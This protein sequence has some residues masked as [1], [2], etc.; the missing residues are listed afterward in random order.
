MR[1]NTVRPTHVSA[2][3]NILFFLLLA[4]KKHGYD[5]GKIDEIC[6]LPVTWLQQT[7]VISSES[8]FFVEGCHSSNIGD[9]LDCDLHNKYHKLHR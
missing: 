7:N 2:Y 6:C 1:K 8:V 9:C 5:V 4:L 3:S